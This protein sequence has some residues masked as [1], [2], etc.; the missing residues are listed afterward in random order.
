MYSRRCTYVVGFLLPPIL[1]VAVSISGSNFLP[2]GHA[3]QQY[4][5][6]LPVPGV[7]ANTRRQGKFGT[8]RVRTPLGALS[9]PP[10]S[11]PRALH[12]CVDQDDVRHVPAYPT[13]FA[14]VYAIRL[15][16]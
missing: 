12:R 2:E 5:C 1:V 11:S 15:H 3:A 13:V 14:T 4:L 7:A 6:L 9:V 8:Q 10:D 16:N